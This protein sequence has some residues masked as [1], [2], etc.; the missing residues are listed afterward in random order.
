MAATCIISDVV[1]DGLA[2]V[3]NEISIRF[4]GEIALYKIGIE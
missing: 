2:L 4:I 3:L 1:W